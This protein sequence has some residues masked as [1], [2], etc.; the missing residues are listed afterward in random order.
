MSWNKS[1]G[2][3]C[4]LEKKSVVIVVVIVSSFFALAAV[5][6]TRLIRES[7]PVNEKQLTQQQRL[8][9]LEKLDPRSKA[10]RRMVAE[11]GAN[12]ETRKDLERS[13]L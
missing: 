11:E 8:T 9:T 1:C 6:V 5:G 12:E 7:A 4:V 13:R 10:V 2:G 3:E